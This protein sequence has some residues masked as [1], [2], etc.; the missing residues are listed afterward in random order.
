MMLGRSA[1]TISGF[2]GRLLFNTGGAVV[3]ELTCQRVAALKQE[4]REEDNHSH[5]GADEES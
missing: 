2:K 5:Q 1:G 3:Q 4:D